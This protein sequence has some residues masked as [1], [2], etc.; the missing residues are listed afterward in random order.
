M[1]T[2]DR[3]EELARKATNEIWSIEH[4]VSLALMARGLKANDADY[5]EAANPETILRLVRAARAAKEINRV[6]EWAVLAGGCDGPLPQDVITK[7]AEMQ[8]PAM[9]ELN[10]AL[11]ELE[12]P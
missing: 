11:S 9:N 7:F 8:L 5:V 1:S 3:L 10:A 4:A 6:H 12:K 2:L